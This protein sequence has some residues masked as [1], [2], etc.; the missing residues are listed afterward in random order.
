[1]SKLKLIVAVA[2][3]SFA[4]ISV[5]SAAVL[6]PSSSQELRKEISKLINKLDITQSLDT[7]TAVNLKFT[8]NDKNEIIVLSTDN[9][10]F[11]Y[12]FK[13]A[14]NYKELDTEGLDANEIYS[15]RVVLKPGI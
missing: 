10:E 4:S 6:T 12:N 11:D 7:E 2:L 15:V 9:S 14:L 1:M 3:F 5:S 8:V 13:G